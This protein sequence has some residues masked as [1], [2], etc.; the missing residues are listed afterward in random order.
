M[1]E[2]LG[3]AAANGDDDGG[4]EMVAGDGVMSLFRKEESLMDFLESGVRYAFTERCVC[5]GIQQNV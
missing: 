5:R 1:R 3:W 4:E 2:R